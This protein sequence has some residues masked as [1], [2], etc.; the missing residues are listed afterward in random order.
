MTKTFV[1]PSTFEI[2]R[3]APPIS[4]LKSLWEWLYKNYNQKRKNV[5]EFGAG[6][7]S[8]VLSDAVEPQNQVC[9]E[10][11]PL[12]INMVKKHVPNIKVV[13]T[14]WSGIPKGSYD[15]LFVDSCTAPPPGLKPLKF[16]VPFRDDAI[17]YVK[18]M[19]TND[20]VVIIHDWCH[21]D[22]RWREHRRYLE[23]NGFKLIWSCQGRFG[24]GAYVREQK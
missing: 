21:K 8:W 2:S 5:L 22:F 19:L 15:L 24:F 3:R 17:E 23:A 10:T 18:A 16:E 11:F 1:V 6:I 20:A 14:N 13:N 7:T 12:C 9:M 4:E